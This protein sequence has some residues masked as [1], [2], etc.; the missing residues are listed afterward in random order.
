MTTYRCWYP[1]QESEDEGYEVEAAS[2]SEAA[3]DYAE[4]LFSLDLA[5][6]V[7]DTIPLRVRSG[8][9]VYEISVDVVVEPSF[10]PGIPFEVKDGGDEGL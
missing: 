10:Y 1:D 8:E 5:A 4:G 9:K 3:C 6:G 7:A 2:I